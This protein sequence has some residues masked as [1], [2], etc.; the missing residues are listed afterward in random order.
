MHQDPR[1]PLLDPEEDPRVGAALDTIATA[2]L[3]PP[4]ELTAHRHRRGIARA[5]RGQPLVVA[6]RS[7]ATGV[8][9]AALVGVLAVVGA[10]PGPA[11]QVA[12]DLAA[13]VG[14]EL[15]RPASD[16]VL[17]VEADTSSPPPDA[18]STEPDTD[19]TD[20]DSVRGEPADA[21]RDRADGADAEGRESRPRGRGAATTGQPGA[22]DGATDPSEGRRPTTPP[23][24]RR[25]AEPPAPSPLPVPSDRGRAPA[26]PPTSPPAPT[27]APDRTPG[28]TPGTAPGA[29][30][31]PAAPAPPAPRQPDAG[32]G[33]GRSAG[34]D[35]GRAPRSD[36]G[37]DGG[38]ERPDE[39]AAGAN[40]T[41]ATDPGATDPTTGVGHRP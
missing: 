15:P 14:L 18:G 35:D 16:E 32:A 9:A 2:L 34:E 20:P 10:L 7:L 36:D 27:P 29:D 23:S 1:D 4:D 24:S 30:Q 8:A 17:P 40:A 28:S 19:P 21:G 11:Q 31:P 33:D 3:T 41:P 12:A 13:R 38:G 37:R 25:P 39:Q 5:R 6:Q 22:G 26:N